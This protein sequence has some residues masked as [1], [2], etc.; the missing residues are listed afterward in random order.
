MTTVLSIVSG[1]GGVGKTTTTLNLAAALAERNHYVTVVD[2]NLTTPNISLHLGIPL[3]PTTLHDVLQGKTD[4]TKAVYI[5]ESGV[6]VVPA[7]L[8]V[9][10]LRGIKASDLQRALDPL[11]ERKGWILLDGAAGLGKEARTVMRVSDSSIIVTNPGIPAVTDALKAIKVA[12]LIGTPV[13]GIIINRWTGKKH[14]M[15]LKQ[16]SE[17]LEKPILGVIPEDQKIQECISQK[18]M[19]F[20]THPQSRTAYRYRY[21]VSNILGHPYPRPTGLTGAFK[22]VFLNY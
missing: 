10:H 21:I 2:G 17:M 4:I 7:S 18:K 22:R 20:H 6:R 11:V 19:F 5:H 8:S 3:F 15:S 16:I 13:A 14:Q 12:N 9:E 1:K